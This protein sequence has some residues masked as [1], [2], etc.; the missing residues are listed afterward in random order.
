MDGQALRSTS[1]HKQNSL[2]PSHS[3][4]ART[5]PPLRLSTVCCLRHGPGSLHTALYTGVSSCNAHSH[6]RHSSHCD[7]RVDPTSET[8][9]GKYS[10]RFTILRPCHGGGPCVERLA[11]A[12]SRSSFSR[13]DISLSKCSNNIRVFVDCFLWLHNLI[14]P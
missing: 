8:T 9:Q 4:R 6:L 14:T 1:L 3:R 10:T 12:Y 5:S 7:R 2:L 13:L 11:I